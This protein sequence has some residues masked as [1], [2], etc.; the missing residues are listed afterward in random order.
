MPKKSKSFPLAPLLGFGLLGSMFGK[1]NAER[2]AKS[3]R[4]R[5]KIEVSWGDDDCGDC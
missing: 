1:M 5:V 3:G 2:I 4:G